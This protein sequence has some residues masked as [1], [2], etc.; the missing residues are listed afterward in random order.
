M[1]QV[2]AA[3]IKQLQL[4]NRK[5]HFVSEDQSARSSQALRDVQPELE[6]LRV[7]AVIK[8]C[9]FCCPPG[10]QGRL[11]TYANWTETDIVVLAVSG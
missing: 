10:H 5:L 6:R 2:N 3:Y 11:P 9:T 7:K 4:L 8:V 1:C